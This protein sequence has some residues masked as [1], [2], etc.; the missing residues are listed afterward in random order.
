MG[1]PSQPGGGGRR[2]RGQNLH[3]SGGCPPSPRPPPGTPGRDASCSAA[4]SLAVA[5]RTLPSPLLP[6]LTLPPSS[7]HP[8]CRPFIS[9]LLCPSPSFPVGLPGW[10][11]FL[12]VVAFPGDTWPALRGE[13]SSQGLPLPPPPAASRPK[14]VSLSPTPGPPGPSPSELSLG[15]ALRFLRNSGSP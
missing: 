9:P 3:Q 5:G 7:S 10:L 1:V 15:P 13:G 8:R 6:P 12:T 11:P 2:G 4:L 14:T